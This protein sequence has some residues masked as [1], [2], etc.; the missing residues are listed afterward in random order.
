MPTEDDDSKAG[1]GSVQAFLRDFLV[2][3]STNTWL[4]FL[5]ASGKNVITLGNRDTKN[6]APTWAWVQSD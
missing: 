6:D 4:F 3:F 1:S 5:T 2:F